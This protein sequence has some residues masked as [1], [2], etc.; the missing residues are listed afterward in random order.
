MHPL[1][2]RVIGPARDRRLVCAARGCGEP[3]IGA[4]LDLLGSWVGGVHESDF[5]AGR[6]V[7]LSWPLD[8]DVFAQ[9][10]SHGLSQGVLDVTVEVP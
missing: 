6:Y 7:E 9:L 8:S 4:F 1:K 3:I 5:L 2:P 10:A